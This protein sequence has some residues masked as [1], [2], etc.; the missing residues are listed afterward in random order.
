MKDRIIPLV[1]AAAGAVLALGM[2]TFAG[3]CVHED[4][5]AAACATAAH[6]V[7]AAGIVACVAG[8]AG[9]VMRSIPA[10]AALSIAGIVAGVFAT[11][12][13]GGLFALCMVQTMRCWT[14]MRPFA[15]VFGIVIA[16]AGAAML[17]RAY[18]RNRKA[19]KTLRRMARER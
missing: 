13:P 4:G 11:I 14:I 12:A 16:F 19:R 2:L 6:A 7:L 9:A 3:P 1:L 15:L 17:F 5:S 18:A 8:L 10:Q